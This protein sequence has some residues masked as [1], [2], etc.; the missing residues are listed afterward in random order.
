MLTQGSIFQELYTNAHEIG[1]VAKIKTRLSL[2]NSE[3]N[4]YYKED[5]PTRE[6]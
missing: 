3:S 2:Q 4:E 1:M 5:V 6:S